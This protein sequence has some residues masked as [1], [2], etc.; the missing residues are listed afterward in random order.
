MVSG[1]NQ[2]KN[3]EKKLTLIFVEAQFSGSLLCVLILPKNMAS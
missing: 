1:Q 3:S 2:S